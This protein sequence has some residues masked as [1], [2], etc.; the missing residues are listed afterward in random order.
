M[1]LDHYAIRCHD[2]VNAAKFYTEALGYKIQEEFD[3]DLENG[4]KAKCIALTPP[5]LG[6]VPAISVAMEPLSYGI[7][8]RPPDV[9]IS[10]GTPDSVVGKW[11]AKY[12]NGIGQIHHVAYAVEDVAWEMKKWIK[13]GWAEFTTDKPIEGPD[14]IQCF[15]KPHPFTG[16]TYELVRRLG[17]VGFN[18][19]NVKQLMLSTVDNEG[20][21]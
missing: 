7:Y 20:N 3:I 9:F 2:R 19:N 6:T 21:D 15:T 4:Q 8:H 18:K 12:G 10:D 13:N 11:V 5:E 17:N 16:V 14:I 1:R